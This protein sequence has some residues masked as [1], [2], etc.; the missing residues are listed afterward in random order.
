MEPLLNHFPALRTPFGPIPTGRRQEY[1]QSKPVKYVLS[2]SD[3][4]GLARTKGAFGKGIANAKGEPLWHGEPRSPAGIL[5]RK[6]S[7]S[8]STASPFV[9]PSLFS[10]LLP[11]LSRVRRTP[12]RSYNGGA[13][14][15]RY[16]RKPVPDLL[17]EMLGKAYADEGY[18]GQNLFDTLF[19][20]GIELV[21]KNHKKM[22]PRFL[23][24]MDELLLRKRVIIETI[25]DQC[26]SACINSKTSRRLSTRATARP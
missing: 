24:L 5:V 19:V 22:K 18:I 1:L 16:P 11:S 6:T 21:T 14:F 23:N 7:P 13:L 25:I 3:A 2:R 12:S 26:V 10:S 20:K 4:P 15:P 9:A 17:K 8:C